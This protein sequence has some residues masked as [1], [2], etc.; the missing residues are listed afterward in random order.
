MCSCAALRNDAFRGCSNDFPHGLEMLSDHVA[1]HDAAEDVDEASL[2]TLHLRAV[3]AALAE[4]VQ[5]R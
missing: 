1:G 4:V 5:R 2:H 3:V